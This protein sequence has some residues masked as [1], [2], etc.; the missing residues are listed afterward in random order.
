[1]KINDVCVCVVVVRH[2]VS[3]ATYIITRM[4]GHRDNFAICRA[5]HLLPT[6]TMFTIVNVQF[7]N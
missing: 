4:G 5:F 7:Y 3:D 2:V 1:M 6:P